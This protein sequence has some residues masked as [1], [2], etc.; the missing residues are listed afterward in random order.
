MFIGKTLGLLPYGVPFS[1]G[2]TNHVS[3]EQACGL[4]DSL[5]ASAAAADL[6]M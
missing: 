5:K 4:A 6:M 1:G 3:I 2:Y